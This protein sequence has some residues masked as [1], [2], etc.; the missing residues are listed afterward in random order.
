MAKVGVALFG[1]GRIG[2]IHLP[3][4]V[5]NGDVIVRWLVDVEAA[6]EK[7]V[8][9]CALYKLENTRFAA[10]DKCEEVFSD[11]S[12]EAVIVG[13]P[14]G[15]HEDLIKKSVKAGKHVRFEPEHARL[16]EQ[17]RSGELGTPRVVH[18]NARDPKT[19][20]SYISTSGGIFCD[21]CIHL[22]DYVT[23]LLDERP[24]SVVATG[25]RTSDAKANY[26]LADDVDST[27][28]TLQFPSGVHAVLE[29]T[30][31]LPINFMYL[32]LETVTTVALD[33]SEQESKNP[34]PF[35]SGY[36][37]EMDCF[38]RVVQGKEECPVQAD[39]VIQASMLADLCRTSLKEGRV[40]KL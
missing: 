40:V 20:A 39:G 33:G 23:W 8:E 27:L 5:A 31:E 37:L 22:L 24:C 6:R 35:M 36:K 13:T 3:N 1:L 19:P 21:S 7:A 34:S 38:I 28:I 14:T 15:F 30:R 11:A 29:V 18:Y 10:S 9:L 32:R 17:L 25:G 16:K 12:T 2:Q 26:E 4:L